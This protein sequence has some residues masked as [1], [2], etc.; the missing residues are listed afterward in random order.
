MEVLGWLYL[1]VAVMGVIIGVA[2]VVIAERNRRLSAFRLAWD[3]RNFRDGVD[4]NNNGGKNFVIIVL[5]EKS[6]ST[7]Q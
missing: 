1:F 5:P 7:A 2:N 4:S 3:L 6:G